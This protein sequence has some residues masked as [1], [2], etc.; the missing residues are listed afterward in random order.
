MAW[1]VNIDRAVSAQVF[2]RIAVDQLQSGGALPLPPSG[3]EQAVAEALR[4]ANGDDTWL[5]IGRQMAL[6]K[7]SP[8]FFGTYLKRGATGA[9]QLVTI[10]AWSDPVHAEFFSTRFEWV[11]PIVH[12][13]AQLAPHFKLPA[14]QELRDFF[15]N[16]GPVLP[17]PMQP[18]LGIAGSLANLLL[19]LSESSGATIAAYLLVA[20][21]GLSPDLVAALEA[22]RYAHKAEFSVHAQYLSGIGVDM[23]ANMAHGHTPWGSLDLGELNGSLRGAA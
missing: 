6:L 8:G 10:E 23:P 20:P 7:D 11:W 1:N 16:V 12:G 13:I 4:F 5:H 2:A 22:N 19:H 21:N 3:T 17:G 15:S 14:E 18:Y 9:L